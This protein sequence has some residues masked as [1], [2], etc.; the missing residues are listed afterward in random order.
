VPVL[1]EAVGA[2]NIVH[3]HAP[4]RAVDYAMGIIAKQWGQFDSFVENMRA[5][6][7]EDAVE[8]VISRL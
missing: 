6:Q 1:S 7:D 2:D 8:A 3:V 4:E 5:R